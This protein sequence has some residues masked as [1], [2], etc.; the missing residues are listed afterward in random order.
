MTILL[1]VQATINDFGNGELS[2]DHRDDACNIL[3]FVASSDT[4]L[5]TVGGS[6]YREFD[7]DD[8]DR[9]NRKD[10]TLVLR[11]NASSMVSIRVHKRPDFE[12]LEAALS[13]CSRLRELY[14][15]QRVVT[16]DI[17]A[18]M[19]RLHPPPSEFQRY[20]LHLIMST[21]KKSVLTCLY[22][23]RG[24][25]SESSGL[26]FLH[27][28]VPFDFNR[29]EVIF[30]EI[31]LENWRR[32]RKVG[33]GSLC[34]VCSASPR[35]LKSCSLCPRSFCRECLEELTDASK[36][37]L[38]KPNDA[39][40][41]MACLQDLPSVQSPVLHIVETP[42]GL[43]R[44]D[45]YQT[46]ARRAVGNALDPRTEL[47][48]EYVLRHA[49]IRKDVSEGHSEDF[50]F[51]CKDGGELL[52]CE[53]EDCGKVFHKE[54][55]QYAAPDDSENQWSCPRHCCIC[56]GSKSI[57]FACLYCPISSCVICFERELKM[58]GL[59][60]FQV[61]LNYTH[62]LPG[63]V[64]N[65]ICSD[66][67]QYAKKSFS[68]QKLIEL[69]VNGI[70]RPLWCDEVKVIADGAKTRVAANA[71]TSVW[72]PEDQHLLRRALAKYPPPF[73]RFCRRDF[74]SIIRDEEFHAIAGYPFK[75]FKREVE[76]ITGQ[77][78]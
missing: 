78:N 68:E 56:C 54:C 7:K 52:E 47:F 8:V 55:L 42:A 48:K 46:R 36:L 29:K 15:R 49:E 70:L 75:S 34:S 26:F 39:W 5:G 57:S 59:L 23:G 77:N 18:T 67:I 9:I 41:C 38:A 24:K 63:P 43:N 45:V 58:S 28:L 22:C 12:Y 61:L 76:Y 16:N 35:V 72:T 40:T 50:C 66:C 27:P 60:V 44:L 64:I 1:Q 14:L 69:Q 25:H 20:D 65:I 11:V 62:E 37:M 51:A 31:C 10:R 4:L 13:Q 53:E 33:S 3:V 2:L 30:C 32:Y 74:D 6:T 19:G 21:R 73:P 17:L 71:H